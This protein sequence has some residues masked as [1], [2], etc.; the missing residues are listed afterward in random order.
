MTTTP[1]PSPGP[2]GRAGTPVVRSSPNQIAPPPSSAPG[3]HSPPDLTKQRL[4]RD[5][6]TDRFNAPTPAR[7]PVPVPRLAQP[8]PDDVPSPSN[9]NSTKSSTA[10]D[11]LTTASTRDRRRHRT[12]CRHFPQTPRPPLKSCPRP[13]S[14]VIQTLCRGPRDRTNQRSESKLNPA[15]GSSRRTLPDCS[16]KI[17]HSNP[18][19]QSTRVSRN[20]APRRHATHDPPLKTHNDPRKSRRRPHLCS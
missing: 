16:S 3:P 20:Q 17:V 14:S 4:S 7:P 2:L 10:L 9:R 5:L 11:R 15:L 6:P 1:P 19:H 12:P 8:S 18:H 13:R